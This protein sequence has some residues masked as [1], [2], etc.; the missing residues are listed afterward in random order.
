[1]YQ[2]MCLLEVMEVM[3]VMD[4]MEVMDTI[5]TV[6]IEDTAEVGGNLHI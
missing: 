2:F 5:I 4:G 6:I 3:E 1:M